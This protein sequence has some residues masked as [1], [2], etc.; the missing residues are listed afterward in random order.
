MIEVVVEGAKYKGFLKKTAGVVKLT[1]ACRGVGRV[2]PC[3][4]LVFVHV[5]A[6]FF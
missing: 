5:Q 3:R 1:S 2:A 4:G 6:T